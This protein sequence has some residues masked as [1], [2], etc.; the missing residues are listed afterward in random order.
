VAEASDFLDLV[1]LRVA[2]IHRSDVG[3]I[4][5]GAK[6]RLAGTTETRLSELGT[7]PVSD[8]FSGKERV[9]LALAELLAK[10]QPGESTLLPRLLHHAR[11]ELSR[12]ELVGLVMAVEAMQEWEYH[13]E[14]LR[15]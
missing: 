1:R 7:W 9:A 8:A 3:E 12:P 11:E 6:L 10:P 15:A 4:H 14:D 13:R 2:Q 5:Y